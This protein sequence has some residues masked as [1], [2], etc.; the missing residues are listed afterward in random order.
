[1][2][3]GVGSVI[4]GSAPS[5]ALFLVTYESTKSLL[6]GRDGGVEAVDHMVATSLG[7]IAARA[8]RVPT[9]VVKQRAQAS[10]F[11]STWGPCDTSSKV[12]MAR[13]GGCGRLWMELYR[14]WGITV[15]REIPFTVIQ[16]PL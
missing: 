4:A 5:A 16:F 3:K 9:E 13:W 7:E 6:A 14:G 1:M 2:Y 10:Q 8:V 11:P 12:P 15:M